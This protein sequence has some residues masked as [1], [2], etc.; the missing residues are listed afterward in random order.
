[1]KASTIGYNACSCTHPCLTPPL[2]GIPSEFLDETYPA[3]TRGMGLLYCENC[4]ILTSTVFDWSTRVTDGRTDGWAIAYSA[5]SMLSRAKNQHEH[6]S[7]S[8]K[9]VNFALTTVLNFFQI[10]YLFTLL[11]RLH[12]VPRY[13]YLMPI[14]CHFRYCKALL[15]ESRKQRYS[16]YPDLIFIDL[17]NTQ[18]MLLNVMYWDSIFKGSDAPSYKTKSYP[19]ALWQSGVDALPNITNYLQICED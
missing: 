6:N 17:Y 7:Q 3:K 4:L 19:E 15:F 12:T 9:R 1:M 13:H 11:G 16:K 10:F 2:G 5:L 8:H 18:N 14:S